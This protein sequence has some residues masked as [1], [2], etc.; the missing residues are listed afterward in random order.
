MIKAEERKEIRRSEECKAAKEWDAKFEKMVN[1][2][3]DE[4]NK[5]KE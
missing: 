5:N 2:I 3:I 4:R 1:N